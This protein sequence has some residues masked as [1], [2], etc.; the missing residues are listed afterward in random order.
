VLSNI[1]PPNVTQLQAL[2]Q[3]DAAI[4]KPTALNR[5]QVLTGLTWLC[6]RSLDLWPDSPPLQLPGLQHLEVKQGH[7]TMPMPFLACCTQLHV[8]KLCR[9][10]L[11]GPGSLVASSM[12]QLLE[13]QRCRVSAADGA[14]G[15]ISWQQVFPGPRRLPHLTSLKLINLMPDL[16][17]ADMEC[18]AARC[19]SLQ[20]LHLGTLPDNSGSALAS[21]SGLTSLNLRQASDQQCGSLAQLTVLREL[22]VAG[23]KE[24]FASGLQQLAALEQL[25]SL[26]L[27]SSLGWSSDVL[28][29]HMSDTLPG[30]CLYGHAIINKVCLGLV[31]NY[32]TT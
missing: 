22:R 3:L 24:V 15:P 27:Q 29:Q 10:N 12:L 11:S 19:S 31:D 6:V 17:R 13:L 5:L 14:A 9:I 2:Q 25:T 23:A 32:F 26:E 16:Q 30:R 1:L 4:A 18:V 21:L 28:R 8:L 20:A 7:G